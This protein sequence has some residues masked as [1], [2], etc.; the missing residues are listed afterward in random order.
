MPKIAS[1]NTVYQKVF[2]VNVRM[3]KSCPLYRDGTCGHPSLSLLLPTPCRCALEST[4]DIAE[5]PLEKHPVMLRRVPDWL[6]EAIEEAIWKHA[7]E[8]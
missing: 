5:C 8:G 3:P 6:D 4:D 7:K 2:D 1:R